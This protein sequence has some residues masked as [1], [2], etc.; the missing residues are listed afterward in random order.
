MTPSF[1]NPQQRYFDSG[2]FF[3]EQ[4]Q[5]AQHQH[6][7]AASA[8]GEAT[9]ARAGVSTTQGSALATTVQDCVPATPPDSPLARGSASP[10]ASGGASPLVTSADCA[11]HA[12]G[13]PPRTRAAAPAEPG[14]AALPII[15]LKRS[16]S[17]VHVAEEN[18]SSSATVTFDAEPQVLP[19]AVAVLKA[20]Q[21]APEPASAASAGASA[22]AGAAMGDVQLRRSQRSQTV[23]GEQPDAATAGYNPAQFQAIT[24]IE[25]IRNILMPRRVCCPFPLCHSSFHIH[26]HV[27]FTLGFSCWTTVSPGGGCRDAVTAGHELPAA[28]VRAHARAAAVAAPQVA[29]QRRGLQQDMRERQRGHDKPRRARCRGGRRA[30]PSQSPH[31]PTAVIPLSFSKRKKKAKLDTTTTHAHKNNTQTYKNH[32]QIIVAQTLQGKK[33]SV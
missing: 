21:P 19:S 4:E 30:P 13:T 28:A 22:A 15:L 9:G 32:G 20:A 16:K 31:T 6:R 2:D 29:E 27:A 23:C 1:P 14:A 18:G 33:K 7:C 26:T 8:A 11:E 10:L 5:L 3:K 24:S 12:A 17:S 25:D